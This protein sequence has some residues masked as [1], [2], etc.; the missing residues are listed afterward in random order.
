MVVLETHNSQWN[1]RD[2]RHKVTLKVEK[3]S[4]SHGETLNVVTRGQSKVVLKV[5]NDPKNSS[6]SKKV[7]SLSISSYNLVSQLERTPAQIFIFEL[8]ELS[9]LHKKIL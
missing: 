2:T 7:A 1:S 3:S 9:P 6:S 5:A 4:S 8:L